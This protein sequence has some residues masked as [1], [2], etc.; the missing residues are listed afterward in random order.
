MTKLCGLNCGSE[1]SF[2]L[3]GDVEQIL[4]DF[5]F[6]LGVTSL[7]VALYFLYFHSLLSLIDYEVPDMTRLYLSQVILDHLCLVFISFF[8]LM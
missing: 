2:G 4:K 5:F 7:K 3:Y 6:S 8:P 1:A